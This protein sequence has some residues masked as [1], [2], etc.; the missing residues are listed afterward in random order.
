L[1]FILKYIK[2]IFFILKNIF[3]FHVSKLFK[4][5]LIL[6]NNKNLLNCFKNIFQLPCQTLSWSTK[7]LTQSRVHQDP[8]LYLVGE[9]MKGKGKDWFTRPTAAEE[10][11]KTAIFL[12][13]KSYS[14]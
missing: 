6:K 9:E 10:R 4:N 7:G 8:R 3:N 14:L 11:A 1:L 12:G 5:I 13:G 2:I